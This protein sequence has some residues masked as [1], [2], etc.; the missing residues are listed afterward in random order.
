VEA[1]LTCGRLTVLSGQHAA[2]QILQLIAADFERAIA[3]GAPL[4][5][6]LGNIGLG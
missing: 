1:L 3:C 2:D 4:V 6:L 5:R